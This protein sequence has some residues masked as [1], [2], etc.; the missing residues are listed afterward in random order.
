M[1]YRSGLLLCGGTLMLAVTAPVS[2]RADEASEA[3]LKKVATATKSIQTLSAD[4][5]LSQ[6]VQTGDGK[7]HDQKLQGTV[8]LKRPNLA[9]IS[10]GQGSDSMQEVASNGTDLYQVFGNQYIKRTPGAN[11]Q[12]IQAMWAFQVNMF[13]NPNQLPL[14]DSNSKFLGKETVGG[15]D[16][17]VIEL[18]PKA[19]Q[20][21]KVKLY[22]SPD[23]LIVQAVLSADSANQKVKLSATLRNIKR[24]I[25]LDSAAFAYTPPKSASPYK[26]PDYAA[27]LIAVGKDAPKFE[28]LRPEGG[29]ISLENTLKDKKAVL[30][31]F[32]FYG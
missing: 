31:N 4:L 24:N 27:N 32:W 18:T 1:R 25:T 30:V 12:N 2:S 20:E 26:E 5:E 14:G 28:L 17:Q 15:V 6:N 13:F 22:V 16:Y 29:K 23:N 10:V 19:M 11:G 8:K 7:K 3:L 9:R 21:E